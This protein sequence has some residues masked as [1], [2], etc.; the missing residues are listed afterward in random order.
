MVKQ[1]QSTVLSLDAFEDYVYDA[2][3]HPLNPA[4]FATVDG[5]GHLDL[6]NLNHSIESPK[7]CLES[8]HHR[9]LA[10][11]HCSWSNDGRNIVTGDSEGNLAVYS[12][13]KSIAQ[14]R[15]EDF[16]TFQEKVRSFQPVMPRNV[17]GV[18]GGSGLSPSGG[19]SVGFADGGRH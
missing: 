9:K 18:G 15:N 8:P 5:E 2:K 12:V 6:W 13:E 19:R 16:Q 7:V 4:V 1:Y 14:P 17:A 3:W 11:N 10:L